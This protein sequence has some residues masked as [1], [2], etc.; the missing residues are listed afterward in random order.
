MKN[1]EEAAPMP[2]RLRNEDSAQLRSTLHHP[3]P[4]L[5]LIPYVRKTRLQQFQGR[6]PGA[7]SGACRNCRAHTNRRGLPRLQGRH[8]TLPRR[9]IPDGQAWQHSPRLGHHRL[10]YRCLSPLFHEAL[11]VNPRGAKDPAR[12]MWHMASKELS[13][14][15]TLSPNPQANRGG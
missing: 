11:R 10:D 6:L 2:L 14:L 12:Q 9:G 3:N 8:R 1:S 7:C 13:V 15:T 4:I 5:D